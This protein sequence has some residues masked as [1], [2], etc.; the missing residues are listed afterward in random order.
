MIAQLDSVLYEAL[1]YAL[2]GLGIVLTYRYL[3]LI[4]LTF[5]A[6]FVAGPAVAGALLIAGVP[7][8]FALLAALAVVIALA[9]VTVILIWL[10]EVD[11]LLAGLLS[12][13]GGFAIALLFTQGTL[14]LHD[15]ATPFDALKAIDYPWVDGVL[16]LHPSQIAILLVLVLA[17]KIIVDKFLDSELGLAFRAMEDEHSRGFLLAS[18]GISKWRMLT[19]GVVAG[20][21][22]CGIAGTLV[23]LKEGQVTANRGFDALIAVIAA[24]FFGHILFERNPTRGRQNVLTRAIARMAVFRP[25][26][27]ALFGVIFY[28]LLLGIVSRTSLPASIPRLV[29]LG[30]IVVSFLAVRWPDITARWK[31]SFANRSYLVPEDASFEARAITIAYP[32]YPAP[33]EIIHNADISFE[34]GAVVLLQGANGSGKSTLL[35]YLAGLTPGQ[36][37]VSIPTRAINKPRKTSDRKAF[38]AYLSQDAQMSSSATLTV[39]ENLALFQ[40]GRRARWWRKWAHNI[41]ADAP[42]ALASL[43][44]RASNVLAGHLSGGQRQVLN[45]AA[46]MVRPDVPQVILFDEPLTHLDEANAIA[47]VDLMEKISQEGHTLIIVQHDV[48]PDPSG[49]TS[50]VGRRIR[51]LVN[52]KINLKDIQTEK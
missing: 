40:V 43:Y 25:T 37:T 4:D 17:A 14:S 24:Y 47:Y 3:R 23:M 22:L 5:A 44:Q 38:V 9:A 50:A 45:M 26:T 28:F 48:N 46:I 29:M 11:G 16:P 32:G 41:R 34:Q 8:G 30:I 42:P 20:N 36:G 7:F 21:I 10:L 12:S 2:V 13:F 33:V 52:Q 51:A 19:L 6:S 49:Q 31:A 1:P 27:A 35:R 15:V 39:Q 18:I